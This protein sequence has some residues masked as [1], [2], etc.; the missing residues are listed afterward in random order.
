[1]TYVLLACLLLLSV[2]GSAVALAE[3]LSPEKVAVGFSSPVGLAFDGQGNLYVAEWGADRVTRLAPDG[4][5]SVIT[6][7][8]ASPSGLAVDLEGTLRV[9][10]YTRGAVYRVRGAKAEVEESGLRTPAGISPMHDGAYY[11]ADRGLNQVLKI[12]PGGA[13]ET[14]LGNLKTPVGVA[15]FQDGRLVAAELNGNVL[16]HFPNGRDVVLSRVL[17]QPA[18]G[19]VV[20]HENSVAAADYGGTAV[21]RIT[22]DGQTTV[23]ADGLPSP[24]GLA[25]GPDGRL[26]VGCWGDGAIYAVPISP[27]GK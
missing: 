19:L 16:G 11:V 17:K 5:R 8:V 18:V 3:G 14:V 4:T 2:S 7:E 12:V 9:A 10:S 25:L 24:V 23:L 13:R 26:Y 1:M 6:T 27:T 15:R 21:Y 22:L 20:L